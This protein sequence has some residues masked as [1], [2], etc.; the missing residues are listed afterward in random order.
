MIPFGKC[1]WLRASRNHE[2]TD[3]EGDTTIFG[4]KPAFSGDIRIG[5]LP[6]LHDYAFISALAILAEKKHMIENLF[7]SEEPNEAGVFGVK[8]LKD[9]HKIEV[10]IDDFVPVESDSL[11]P[12]FSRCK[13][14][15][16]WVI[17]LQKAYAKING[18]YSRLTNAALP[19]IMRDF[20]GAGESITNDFA[21]ELYD[22]DDPE[23]IEEWKS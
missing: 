16:L 14:D 5:S 18:S 1:E 2:L 11:S 22:L 8:L 9:G 21:D 17:L 6:E 13:Q 3:D 7:I 4:G 19:D 15:Q 20:T 12:A 10:L 23:T